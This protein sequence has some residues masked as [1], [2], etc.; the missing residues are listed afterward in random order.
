M[1]NEFLTVLPQS[2]ID[3]VKGRQT[4]YTYIVNVTC[5]EGTQV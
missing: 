3:E 5:E 4:F 1:K 2:D